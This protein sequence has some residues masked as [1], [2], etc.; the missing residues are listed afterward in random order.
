MTVSKISI[1]SDLRIKPL[2]PEF[3]SGNECDRCF[4]TTPDIRKKLRLSGDWYAPVHLVWLNSR[5]HVYRVAMIRS[6]LENRHQPHIH[7]NE[8][9][10][11]L[12]K[13]SSGS[14]RSKTPSV[15]A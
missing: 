9:E 6:Y 3:L 7:L 11:L 15:A 13:L 8:A 10:A 14:G 12:Q 4:G 2:E 5:Y 1:D